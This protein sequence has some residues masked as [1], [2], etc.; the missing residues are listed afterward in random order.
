MNSSLLLTVCN[1]P[2]SI[3]VTSRYWQVLHAGG[4]RIE[5][6]FLL[7]IIAIGLPWNILVVIAILRQK[8][9]QQ[10]SILLLLNLSI[11]DILTLLFSY[12]IAAATA[13]ASEFFSL[14]TNDKIKCQF[15][16]AEIVSL[17][18]FF[19]S[20]FLIGLM[21]IDRLV[22]IVKPL[23]YDQIVTSCRVFAAMTFTFFLSIAIS[24]STLGTP[25]ARAFHGDILSCWIPF[26]QNN[27][28]YF[29][30]PIVLGLLNLSVIILCNVWV[31][32]IVQKNIK[33]IYKSRKSDGSTEFIYDLNKKIESTRHRK[34]L[35]LFRVF[36]AILLANTLCWLPI[37]IIVL[38]LLLINEFNENLSVAAIFASICLVSIVLIHPVLETLLLKDVRDSLKSMI[39]CGLLT[40]SEF[41]S[42][43][44]LVLSLSC[45]H[46]KN[47]DLKND[48]CYI[49]ILLQAGTL[50]QSSDPQV[51]AV[52]EQT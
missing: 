13:I 7:F 44:T 10:P 17:A 25:V 47:W 16:Y 39:S 20:F 29:I 32:V 2:S 5:A 49:W 9:Y 48:C 3:N 40:K 46:K 8:L 1:D 23:K 34:Q 43:N 31:I 27:H 52:P 45:C 22:F 37:T 14:G 50:P 11:A 6:G 26:D 51:H 21:S 35:H 38:I 12:P 15:C 36:G 33:V 42:R 24:V 4:G 18:Q 28:P 19:E 41:R 30:A